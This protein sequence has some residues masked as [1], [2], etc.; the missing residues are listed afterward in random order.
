MRRLTFDQFGT[1]D[2][3]DM[4]E[5][6]NCKDWFHKGCVSIPW[7]SY[8]PVTNEIT[9]YSCRKCKG[10]PFLIQST[11]CQ[12][13]ASDYVTTTNTLALPSLYSHLILNTLLY[14]LR[15]Y[16]T[17]CLFLKLHVSVKSNLIS[18][19]ASKEIG[20]ASCRERV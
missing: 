20:R 3:D 14:I 10:G 19:S 6:Q 4:V 17:V 7:T 13:E 12:S 1:K 5:C 2:K 11:A 18:K 8:D 16:C 15:I 9:D